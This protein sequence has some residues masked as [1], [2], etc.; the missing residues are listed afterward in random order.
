MSKSTPRRRTAGNRFTFGPTHWK[1]GDG[2]SP[3]AAL[4]AAEEEANGLHV[5]HCPDQ[6]DGGNLRQSTGLGDGLVNST[7]GG[8][9]G[10]GGN[11]E[12]LLFQMEQA[13]ERSGI[14]DDLLGDIRMNVNI[15]VLVTRP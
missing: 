15:K 8:V 4:A 1:C 3:E 13:L 2:L 10:P 7:Y 12:R 9:G 6:V 11:Q 14:P 5:L